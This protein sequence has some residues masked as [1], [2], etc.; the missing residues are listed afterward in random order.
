M[1]G[2]H[3]D[4]GPRHLDFPPPAVLSVLRCANPDFQSSDKTVPW[5]ASSHSGSLR[6][7]KEKAARAGAGHYA[8]SQVWKYWGL[9]WERRVK[10]PSDLSEMTKKARPG[11]WSSL[12]WGSPLWLCKRGQN[13][14]SSD[15][16]DF[17]HF[18]VLTLIRS[19][20]S[21]DQYSLGNPEGQEYRFVCFFSWLIT[22]WVMALQWRRIFFFV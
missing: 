20:Q 14:V 12:L 11:A 4:W 18:Q 9:W 13:A 5:W 2:P 16:Y 10:Q 1:T 15:L 7:K 6:W 19:P 3:T 21:S 22:S 8:R 17:P